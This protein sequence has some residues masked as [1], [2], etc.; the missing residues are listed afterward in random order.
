MRRCGLHLAL[1][2]VTLAA[3]H[4]ALACGSSLGQPTRQIDS[5]ELLLMYKTTPDPVQVGR[6]FTLQF[7]LCPRGQ[8]ALPAEVRVD[9][10]MPEHKHG[11][12]YQPSV[13]AL[14]PGLYRAEGLM[15]HMPGRWELVFELRGAGTPLRLAQSLQID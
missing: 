10:H 11:M 6:H 14:G 15:F 7:A 8:T 12:N 4:A 1:A 13:A 9:A 2:C 3:S 5:P